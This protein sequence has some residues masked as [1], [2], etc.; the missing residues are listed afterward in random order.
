MVS[1]RRRRGKPSGLFSFIC[2]GSCGL[3]C[4]EPGG[5]IEA[6]LQM[7]PQISK[8]QEIQEFEKAGSTTSSFSHFAG[9]YHFSAAGGRLLLGCGGAEPARRLFFLPERPRSL[10]MGGQRKHARAQPDLHQRLELLL[11][12]NTTQ[13]SHT[14]ACFIANVYLCQ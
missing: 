2:S 11:S 4:V 7:D 8:F 14:H 6:A 5:H 13:T 9:I 1:A 3:C 12:F 10:L